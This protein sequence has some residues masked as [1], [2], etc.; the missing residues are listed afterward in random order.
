VCPPGAGD[1]KNFATCG[2]KVTLVPKLTKDYAKECIEAA[3][4][5]LEKEAEAKVA[6]VS[7]GSQGKV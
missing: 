7:V 1:S 3:K 5:V 4:C 2:G 6:E